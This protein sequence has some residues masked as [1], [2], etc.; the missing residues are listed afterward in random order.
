MNLLLI[1]IKSIDKTT[2][3]GYHLMMKGIIL[4]TVVETPEFIKQAKQCMDD[5]T[6]QQFINFIA[7]NP[8]S[9]EII[10]G[11]GGAR[12]IRWQ[13]DLNSGKRG[14]A[15]IIYYYH[16]E[17]MPIYLFTT[18]KKNQRENITAE[19]KAILYKVIK[20]IVKTYKEVNHE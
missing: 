9:G 12:K 2:P 13:S 14:G 18:Y 1:S 19:E 3:L 8:L 15:R 16:D 5:E 17:C 7:E 20:L 6:R 11:T 10:S 4:Q